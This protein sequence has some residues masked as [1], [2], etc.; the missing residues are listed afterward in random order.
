MEIK[1]P[2][3]IELKD[4]YVDIHCF[5]RNP[6]GEG[7]VFVLRKNDYEIYSLLIDEYNCNEFINKTIKKDFDMI[8]WSHPHDDHVE[9]LIKAINKKTNKE[10]KII[11]P[12]SISGYRKCMTFKC[13]CTYDYIK[14]INKF[15]K[16]KNGEYIETNQYTQLLNNKYFDKYGNY[17]DMK[18]RTISP[19]SARV[20]RGRFNKKSNLNELSVSL[21]IS[22]NG[23]EF[24]FTSDIYNEMIKRMDLKEIDFGRVIFYKIPHHGSIESDYILKSIPQYSKRNRIAVSTIY[25]KNGKNVTPSQELLKEYN[26]KGIRIYCTD[27]NYINNIKSNEKVGIVSTRIVFNNEVSKKDLDW[28]IKVYGTA[29]EIEFEKEEIF[30][31]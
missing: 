29:D 12:M 10:S 3:D 26:D 1:V 4:V 15:G 17:I 11:L 13:K 28:D 21:L 31:I 18:I 20:N 22:I 2:D 7:I 8:C 16:N 9:G 19:V 5:G 24:L 25:S 14:I 6:E 30:V 23:V 27:K